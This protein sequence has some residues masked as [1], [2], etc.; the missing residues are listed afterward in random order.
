[1][2]PTGSTSDSPRLS[3]VR[4]TT[5]DHRGSPRMPRQRAGPRTSTGSGHRR[6]HSDEQMPRSPSLLSPPPRPGAADAG[7]LTRR[8][9]IATPASNRLADHRSFHSMQ[10]RHST[11]ATRVSTPAVK[12][13]SPRQSPRQSPHSGRKS[14]STQ[15]FERSTPSVPEED[16][17]L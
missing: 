16:G 8:A 1:L 4:L 15:V 7:L 12:Y 10:R 14:I 2:S 3:R 5:L 9:S 17:L 11:G 13:R 6:A